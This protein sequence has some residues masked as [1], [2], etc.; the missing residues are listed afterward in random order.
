MARHHAEI[1]SD[2]GTEHL[3]L[4]L[5]QVASVDFHLGRLCLIGIPNTV[6]QWRRRRSRRRFL[7]Q[8]QIAR[9]ENVAQPSSSPLADSVGDSDEA[10]LLSI[11]DRPPPENKGLDVS[12]KRSINLMIMAF[13]QQ[14]YLQFGDSDFAALVKEASE[15]SVGST[16]YGNQHECCKNVDCF[17][18]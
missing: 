13:A 7:C 18:D 16:N 9:A 14:L 1:R 17:K 2:I 11:V 15:K 12:N 5:W 8:I 4:K 10:D 6:G 3:L